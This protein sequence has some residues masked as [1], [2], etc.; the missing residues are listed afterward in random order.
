MTTEAEAMREMAASKID[1]LAMTLHGN[2]GD[3]MVEAAAAIRA[4]PLP[5]AALDPRDE[6]LAKAKEALEFYA[7]PETYLAIG[8]FPDRP[9]GDFTDDFEDTGEECGIRPG[10]CAREA[11]AAIEAAMKGGS[12]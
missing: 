3:E 6:A 9:C 12:K 7:N 1:A 11:L 4:L 5:E 10:K 2:A 8:F